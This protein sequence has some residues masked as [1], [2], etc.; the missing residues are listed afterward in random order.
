VRQTSKAFLVAC[1]IAATPNLT[2]AQTAV[3]GTIMHIFAD[4]SDFVVELSQAGGCG[5]GYFHVRRANDNFREMVALALAA[6]T[7]NRTFTVF[8]TGCA[9]DRNVISHG[10]AT[11]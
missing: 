10:Y 9:G 11:R 8:V 7:A 4:P 2:R 5:S 1:V 6:F 3:S